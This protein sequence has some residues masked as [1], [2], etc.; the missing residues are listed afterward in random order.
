VYNGEWLESGATL[1][2]RRSQQLLVEQVKKKTRVEEVTSTEPQ[3]S[4]ETVPI[5]IEVDDNTTQKPV[6]TTSDTWKI[7]QV[8]ISECTD[9]R[10]LTDI[11]RELM[12]LYHV[13]SK[14]SYEL[15]HSKTTVNM[16]GRYLDFTT[17]SPTAPVVARVTTEILQ[18]APLL[19]P[20]PPWYTRIHGFTPE[21]SFN[22]PG[23]FWIHD[24]Y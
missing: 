10:E 15:I 9:Q 2:L 1:I 3:E 5:V 18:Q 24:K 8:Q 22:M 12:N 4:I 16:Y 19:E 20:T 13:A 17:V 21:K 7:L 23:N 14:T 6:G 11:Q